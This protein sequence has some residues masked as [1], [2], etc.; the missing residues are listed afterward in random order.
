MKPL[1]DYEWLYVW[2]MSVSGKLVD[3]YDSHDPDS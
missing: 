3:R 1:V 2:D